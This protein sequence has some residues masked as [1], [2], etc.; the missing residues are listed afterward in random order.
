MEQSTPQEFQ[1]KNSGE[2]PY[3][4]SVYIDIERSLMKEALGEHP[5]A[6]EGSKWVIKHAV[7][8]RKILDTH[9]NLF[10]QWS[11]DPERVTRYIKKELKK[12][13]KH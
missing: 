9:T 5:S 13:D 1:P 10:A 8:F 12:K 7:T 11:R 3:D 2:L 6:E 4:E